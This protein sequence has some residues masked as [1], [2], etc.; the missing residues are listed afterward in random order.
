MSKLPSTG[1]S[2]VGHLRQA[3]RQ[4]LRQAQSSPSVRSGTSVTA[5]DVT[6]V[7][8]LLK[9]PDFDG[10]DR[11]HLGS[12]GWL[13]GWADGL[14]S[15]LVLHGVDVF[16]D[17]ESK[18]ATLTAHADTLTTLAP[19]TTVDDLTTTVSNLSSTVDDLTTTV[20]NLS[21]TVDDLTTTVSNL[22]STVDDLVVT[23]DNLVTTVAGM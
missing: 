8:G 20:S 21:S 11:T 6:T 14:P 18:S 5:L 23:V 16:A 4:A 1:S 13:L 15:M 7:D 22:S 3:Q 2:L 9:S 19:T 10:T 17:I 12:T